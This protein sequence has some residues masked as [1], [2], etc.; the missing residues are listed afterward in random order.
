MLRMLKHN[1]YGRV[2]KGI[3]R[4]KV[5]EVY[6]PNRQSTFLRSH[7]SLGNLSQ[8]VPRLHLGVDTVLLSCALVHNLFRAWFFMKL[9]QTAKLTC[10]AA[11]GNLAHG[12]AD[13]VAHSG[14]CSLRMERHSSFKDL[15]WQIKRQ[16]QNSH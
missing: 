7:H 2:P 11:N 6:D 12:H 14:S 10:T 4:F 13:S 15:P 1:T 16:Y 9:P 3:N 8:Q 5:L